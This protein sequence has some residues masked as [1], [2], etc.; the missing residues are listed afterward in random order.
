MKTVDLET[1][2][3]DFLALGKQLLS[4]KPLTGEDVL[5]E[6]LA[7][8]QEDRVLG[9]PL[10]ES[11][12]MLLLQWGAIH[13]LDITEPL[14]LRAVGEDILHGLKLKRQY[15]DFTRQVFANNEEKSL[16]FDDVAVQM[17]MTLCYQPSTGNEPNSNLW[18]EMPTEIEQ[19]VAKFRATPFVAMLLNSP[20]W[21]ATYK[22]E[23]CG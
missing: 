6:L 4:L 23:Y 17:S 11:A 12:D 9:A 22:V 5:R 16:E 21:H 15:L 3:S 14:D 1:S 20:A 2:V 7:W 10:D 18:I 13:P 19:G 8:Y